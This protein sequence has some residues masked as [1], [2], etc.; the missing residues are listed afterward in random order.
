L[1]QLEIRRRKN[2]FFYLATR[3][4][5]EKIFAMWNFFF[6]LTC[7]IRNDQFVDFLL[8][9]SLSFSIQI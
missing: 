3:E 8:L 1:W 4:L 2:F 9:I 5:A 6:I 7:L